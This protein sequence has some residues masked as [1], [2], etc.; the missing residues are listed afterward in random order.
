[1]GI[2]TAVREPPPRSRVIQIASPRAGRASSESHRLMRVASPRAGRVRRPR[3]ADWPGAAISATQRL[4]TPETQRRRA[5]EYRQVPCLHRHSAADPSCTHQPAML[6]AGVLPCRPAQPC[7][8]RGGG[9]PASRAG[10]AT[11]TRRGTVFPGDPAPPSA[12]RRRVG[13]CTREVPMR[14]TPPGSPRQT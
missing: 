8:P 4:R 10:G 12:V 14:V 1:M 5:P 7:R 3:T 9:H 11:G 2:P 13:R 6:M